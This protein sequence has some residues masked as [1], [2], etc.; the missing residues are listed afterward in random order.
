VGADEALLAFGPPL[1][2]AGVTFQLSTDKNPVEAAANLFA[3][4]RRLDAEGAR[5][6]L[7]GI[8]AMPVPEAGLGLAINDRLQRA[9]APRG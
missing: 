4:L 1:Q 8:A 3:G 9:A 2:G 6:G 5:L 7:R